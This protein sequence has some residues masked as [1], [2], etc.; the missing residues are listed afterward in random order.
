M[1]SFALGESIPPDTAHVSLSSPATLLAAA[2]D[3][4]TQAVSV[5]LP[6]W[7]SNVGYEE[8]EDWVVGRMTTGYPRY[9]SSATFPLAAIANP[10][11]L[12]HSQEHTGPCRGHCCRLW[13]A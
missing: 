9:A 5:S 13:P 1:P 3:A 10:R 12:L 6:T 8:G 11:Q 4:F 2:S 7:Q